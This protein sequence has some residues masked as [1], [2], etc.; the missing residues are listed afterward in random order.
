MNSNQEAYQSRKLADGD[1]TIHHS[2]QSYPNQI[3][4]NQDAYL[5]S[6]G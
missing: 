2:D 3:Q 1:H 5:D 4:Q 6:R